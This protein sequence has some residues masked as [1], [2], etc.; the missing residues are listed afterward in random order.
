MTPDDVDL[1]HWIV[2]AIA[3]AMMLG[4]F[5]AMYLPS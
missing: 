3:C 4:V 5:Y 1:V 2:A